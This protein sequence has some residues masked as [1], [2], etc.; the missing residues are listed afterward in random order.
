MPSGWFRSEAFPP[1]VLVLS[2]SSSSRLWVTET[3]QR[4][5]GAWERSSPRGRL[6]V[7]D[8][9]EDEFLNTI[10]FHVLLR[11]ETDEPFFYQLG[12]CQPYPLA[13]YC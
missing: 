12:Y 10:A 3:F 5:S 7:C 8:N 13:A 2:F 9:K 6:Q 4:P 1:H 11:S